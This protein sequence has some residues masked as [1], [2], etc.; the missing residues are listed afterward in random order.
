MKA[1]FEV[2]SIEYTR[3]AT[4]ITLIQ[5]RVTDDRMGRTATIELV[6]NTPI[7]LSPEQL[8]TLTIHDKP[9]T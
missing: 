2:E 7:N 4:K 9:E 3:T 5:G 6:G 8:V 1:T